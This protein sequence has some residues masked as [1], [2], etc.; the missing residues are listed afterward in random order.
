MRIGNQ[1][2][3]LATKAL[4][5]I[6]ET[7]FIRRLH[8]IRMDPADYF[9]YI[10]S[11]YPV[12]VGFSGALHRMIGLFNS[13]VDKKLIKGLNR[14]AQEEM[15]HNEL[16][17]DMLTI[18]SI[19]HDKLY[20]SYLQY[21]NTFSLPAV[22][23]S[24]ESRGEY[25]IKCHRQKF[26]TDFYP[27]APFPAPVL[28]LTYWQEATSSGLRGDFRNPLI[29]FGCQSAIEATILKVVPPHIYPQV[30]DDPSLN[31][32]Q[33]SISWWQAHGGKRGLGGRESAEERHL[34]VAIE[35]L[36]REVKEDTDLANRVVDAASITL[37]LF[38]A[39]MEWHNT[40]TFDI[41]PY[42]L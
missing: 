14:Q 9:G 33:E 17:R 21:R 8:D 3:V 10:A 32:G 23:S 25:F 13:A 11:M 39:T 36:N 15:T 27:D 6:E 7:N 38:V 1:I 16:W 12:V 34:R 37:D 40:H 4:E 29:H 42:K 28:A 31:L 24:W 18:H 41:T 20:A 35:L 2:D 26:D 22:H 19:N 30:R 5:W